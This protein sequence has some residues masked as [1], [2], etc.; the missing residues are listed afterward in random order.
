MMLQMGN[1]SFDAI[2]WFCASGKAF[3]PAVFLL[4]ATGALFYFLKQKAIKRVILVFQIMALLTLFLSSTPLHPIFYGF[5]LMTFMACQIRSVRNHQYKSL[6]LCLF[7][8]VSTAALLLE[9]PWHISNQISV[10]GVRQ[11]YVVGDSVSAGMGGKDETTWPVLLSEELNI[12]VT[13][14]SMAGATVKSALR[15][16]IPKVVGQGS[17]VFLEIGGNDLL[18]RN[19][20]EE[21]ERD[22]T[23]MIQ[24]LKD[25]SSKIVWME[26][27]LLPQYYPYGRIQRK[28]AQK[29]NIELIPK[30]VLANVFGTPGATSDSIHLTPK[31]HQ[32]MKR[33]IQKL[34]EDERRQP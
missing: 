16:Q 32:V 13:N 12:P 15:R 29:H 28:L 24:Q 17:L 21:Y 11:M 18:N 14:L 9:L 34:L 27:P 31:G 23:E 25:S 7:V 6:T 19:T 10:S 20:A 5:W 8:A 2:L 4:V 30:S 22:L 33:E 26:L 1:I 3:F